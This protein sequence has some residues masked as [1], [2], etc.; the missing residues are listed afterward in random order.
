[1]RRLSVFILCAL[2]TSAM[3]PSRSVVEAT[4][5]VMRAELIA[6]PGERASFELALTYRDGYA[7]NARAPEDERLALALDDGRRFHAGH[8][9]HTRSTKRGENA[10]SKLSFSPL[11]SDDIDAASS[12]RGELTALLCKPTR[13]KRVVLD[14]VWRPAPDS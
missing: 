1:M 8:F 13:C 3:A 4:G 14:L 6:L 9:T 7:L 2:F 10:S 5:G 12:P 11:T